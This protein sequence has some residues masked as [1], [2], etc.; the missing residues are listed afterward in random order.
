MVTSRAQGPQTLTLLCHDAYHVIDNNHKKTDGR[1]A[2]D[3]PALLLMA[4]LP[5]ADMEA[6]AAA[7]AVVRYWEAPD[8]A[9]L[10]AGPARDCRAVATRGDVGLPASIIEALPR[11]EIIACFGVGT[12]AIDLAAARARQVRVTNTPDVLT[13]DVADLA[14]ALMLAVMRRVV[15]ADRF[16]RAGSWT[17]HP[18]GLATR[19]HGKRLGIA[20]FGRIGK[21]LA[22]R[23]SAFG[24]TIGYF[25]R[26]PVPDCPHAFHPTVESLAGDSDILV[27]TLAGGA[28]TSG[29]IGK[30]ALR[31]LGPTGFFVNVARGSVVDEEA[32]IA[33]LADGT[34]AG[35]GLDVFRNEPAID[36]R[37][38]TLPNTVLQPHHGSGTVETRRAMG[39]LLR[40]NLAAHFAGRPLLTPVE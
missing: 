7:H 13:E 17:S 14:F 40:D 27:A 25:A 39:Q 36:P 8:K 26:K 30:A 12:D 38:L 37:F 33:A 10:L 32:L 22:R 18:F 24:M 9:A 35:A 6:L 5:D 23:A 1:R 2:L 29:L 15:E 28:A 34:I 19:L 4:P 16:V 21:A 20:G 31:A 11:L 3:R